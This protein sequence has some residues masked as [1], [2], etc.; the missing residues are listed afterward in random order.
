MESSYPEERKA[1][2]TGA[3]RMAAKKGVA[4]LLLTELA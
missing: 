3:K 1:T 4:E 2:T